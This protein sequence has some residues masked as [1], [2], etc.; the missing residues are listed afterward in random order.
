MHSRFIV[1]QLEFALFTYSQLKRDLVSV[2]V[3]FIVK[4][5]TASNSET[6]LYMSLMKEYAKYFYL[7]KFMAKYVNLILPEY[8]LEMTLSYRIYISL[9]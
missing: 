6:L 3:Y 2:F 8:L 4:L 5:C 9:I 7:E 1:I